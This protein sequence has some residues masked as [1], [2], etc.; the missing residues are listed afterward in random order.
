[1][2]ERT[3]VT[4]SSPNFALVGAGVG[5]GVVS[6]LGGSSMKDFGESLQ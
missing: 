1:M 2:F 3:I 6:R 5:V 4:A